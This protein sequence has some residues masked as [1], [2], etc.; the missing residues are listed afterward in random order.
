ML[1]WIMRGRRSAGLIDQPRR[2]RRSRALRFEALEQRL[3]MAQTVGLFRNM[4][5]SFDGYTLFAPSNNT[6]TYLIDNQGRKVHSWQSAYPPMSS[7]LQPDGSLLRVGRLPGGPF[8]SPG[9]AGIIERFN[10]AGQRTWQFRLSNF[11]VRMHHDIE[12]LPNGNILA[13]AWERKSRSAAIA[14]GRNPSLLPMGELWPDKII[15]IEPSGSSG[16]R[17]VWEWRMWDH[18]VQNFDRRK[19]NFGGVGAH[20]ELINVNY[21]S[22]GAGAGYPPTDWA[23]INAVDYNAALDQIIVSPREFSEFWI[24]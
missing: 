13:I 15:E 2:E 3:P 6:T 14:A 22:S 7:Y 20:P 17:I 5:E 1:G 11:N 10:W 16:G 24:I 9:A 18:L 12:V 21:V 8:N 23:H 19:A 4:P